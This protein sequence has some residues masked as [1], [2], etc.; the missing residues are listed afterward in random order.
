MQGLVEVSNLSDTFG[1]SSKAIRLWNHRKEIFSVSCP[2]E[3]HI[4]G[5]ISRDIDDDSK[6]CRNTASCNILDPERFTKF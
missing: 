6:A 2:Q 5:Y 4:Q 3:H 1:P